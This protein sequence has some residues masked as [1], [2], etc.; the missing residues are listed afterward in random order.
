MRLTWELSLLRTTSIFCRSPVIVHR[1]S[2]GSMVVRLPSCTTLSLTRS[3]IELTL[4]SPIGQP[5]EKPGFSKPFLAEQPAASA[6]TSNAMIDHVRFILTPPSAEAAVPTFPACP[7]LTLPVRLDFQTNAG[8]PQGPRHAQPAQKAS[9]AA[10][11]SLPRRSG[12]PDSLA[13]CARPPVSAA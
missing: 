12:L 11:V 5:K 7:Q 3:S 10:N 1:I 2:I 4:A 9:G 13:C 8:R 6:A